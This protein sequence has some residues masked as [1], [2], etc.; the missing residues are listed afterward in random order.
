LIAWY[1]KGNHS[2]DA[3]A[4]LRAFITWKASAWNEEPIFFC[5]F[6][7]STSECPLHTVATPLEDSLAAIT[8]RARELVEACLCLGCTT[9]AH[10][11]VHDKGDR[12]GVCARP[13]I[14]KEKAGS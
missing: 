5:H 11:S 13:Q 8:I 1:W 9:T 10:A 6:F 7:R 14:E 4:L 2:L 3:H 12:R